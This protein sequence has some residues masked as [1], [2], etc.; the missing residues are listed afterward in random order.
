MIL[1]F[2]ASSRMDFKRLIEAFAVE[3]H[4]RFER[5]CL[6]ERI[7]YLE[8]F[9][10]SDSPSVISE[11]SGTNLEILLNLSCTVRSVESLT[12][13]LLSRSQIS[14]YSFNVRFSFF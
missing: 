6:R 5:L 2:T 4:I 3:E 10:S 12:V 11:P 7:S 13:P 1:S 9:S 8:I 14:K